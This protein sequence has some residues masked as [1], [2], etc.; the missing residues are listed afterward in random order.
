METIWRNPITLQKVRYLTKGV[1][2]VFNQLDMKQSVI[3]NKKYI[4]I[5]L[6]ICKRSQSYSSTD[7]FDNTF[8]FL[9]RNIISLKSISDL[10]QRT[11]SNRVSESV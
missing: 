3:N 6:F 10:F 2:A 4:V 8:L 7:H 1:F 9:Q 11:R 5:L